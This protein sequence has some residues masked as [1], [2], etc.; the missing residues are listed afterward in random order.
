[1]LGQPKLGRQKRNLPLLNPSYFPPFLPSL[2][3]TEVV[4]YCIV[5]D[6]DG[7]ACVAQRRHTVWSKRRAGLGPKSLP[8]VSW[9]AFIF[10]LVNL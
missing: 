6:D 8:M 1:M 10:L 7:R 5:F 4:L 9:G 3:G 2:V